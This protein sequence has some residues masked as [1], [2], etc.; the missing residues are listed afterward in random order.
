MYLTIPLVYLWTGLQP[1]AFMLDDYVRH[2][3]PV[4]LFGVLI[5]RYIQRWLCD[6]LRERGWHWR[7]T[8]L[9][10][11]SWTVYL[12]GLLLAILGVAVP[13]IPTAKERRRARFW[14]LA[15]VPAGIM[16]ISMAT[17]GWTFYRDLFVLAES[18]VRITTEVT[19]G[20]LSFV[21]MN[22]VLMS[23]RLYAAWVDRE[24][25]EGEDQE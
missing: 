11:G 15:W 5:Y 6:P 4:G 13:Y 10:V 12:Q 16:A 20:M 3:L 19:F 17:C 21:V 23:G 8:L 24:R 22:M 9:K 18:E 2:A 1:A 14:K 7:G 25:I